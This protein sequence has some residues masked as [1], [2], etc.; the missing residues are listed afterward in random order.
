MSSILIWAVTR[1]FKG[2]REIN[3]K[4]EQ[5]SSRGGAE[6]ICVGLAGEHVGREAVHATREL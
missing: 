4:K 3:R 2:K 1:N 6:R 5:N